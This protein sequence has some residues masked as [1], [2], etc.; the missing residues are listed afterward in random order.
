[1]FGAFGAQSARLFR[2]DLEC[3][4]QLDAIA[5]MQALIG[6]RGYPKHR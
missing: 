6:L 3:P 1:L 5:C 2:V 4:Q